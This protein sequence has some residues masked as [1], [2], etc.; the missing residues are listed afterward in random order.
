MVRSSSGSRVDS[1]D[2]KFV[3]YRGIVNLVIGFAIHARISIIQA[4]VIQR[5]SE[6]ITTVAMVSGAQI[7][8]SHEMRAH[9]YAHC[10]EAGSSTHHIFICYEYKMISPPEFTDTDMHLL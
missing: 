5:R 4:D 2:L 6:T 1:T 3:A 8:A 10:S 9:L 7:R